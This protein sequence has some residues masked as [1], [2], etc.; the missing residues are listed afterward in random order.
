MTLTKC[1]LFDEMTIREQFWDVINRLIVLDVI[2]TQKKE[3]SFF[4]EKSYWKNAPLYVYYL[5]Y[6]YRDINRSFWN[7]GITVTHV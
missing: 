5:I 1:N 7:H 3:L 2:L 6:N 4:R